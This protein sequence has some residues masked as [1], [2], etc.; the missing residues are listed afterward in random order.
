MQVVQRAVSIHGSRRISSSS[1]SS[2]VATGSGRVTAATPASASASARVATSPP[3]IP[4][5]G[6]A[7]G[8][9]PPLGAAGP[10]TP[11]PL[12]PEG[13]IGSSPGV[14]TTRCTRSAIVDAGSAAESSPSA[15]LRATA[16]GYSALSSAILRSYSERTSTSLRS[17]SASSSASTVSCTDTGTS[18]PASSLSWC[19]KLRRSSASATI[20]VD[21]CC[22]CSRFSPSIAQ[23]NGFL[24]A[25]SPGASA[26]NSWNG[27]MS[28]SHA[29]GGTVSKFLRKRTSVAAQSA[30]VTGSTIEAGWPSSSTYSRV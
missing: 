8:G 26:M 30:V 24:P 7:A 29:S 1:S 27:I 12:P 19:Q 18:S 20:W 4:G 11:A 16:R 13:G 25:R 15:I 28:S 3:L 6:F 22:R 21:T 2:G 10:P 17:S 5:A 14:V 9:T 23:M